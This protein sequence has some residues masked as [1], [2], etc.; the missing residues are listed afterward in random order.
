MRAA[1]TDAGKAVAAT[2][3]EPPVNDVHAKH[4]RLRE[5]GRMVHDMDLMQV[6]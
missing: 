1:W 3:R 2:M 6:K 5:D 4:G